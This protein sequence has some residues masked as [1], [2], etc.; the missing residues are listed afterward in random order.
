MVLFF[1]VFIT[2]RTLWPNNQ[3]AL[4]LHYLIHTYMINAIIIW[5]H[6]I[7]VYYVVY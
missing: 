2:K 1:N 7:I 4:Y 3:H 6:T 5:E